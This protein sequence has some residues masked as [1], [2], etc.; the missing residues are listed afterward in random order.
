MVF[1]GLITSE[2]CKRVNFEDLEF[3]IKDLGLG[4]LLYGFGGLITSETC[5]PVNF[6]DLGL[7]NWDWG[8][9]I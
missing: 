5:K 8:L 1:G 3:R 2:T 9:K 6:E 4:C 7:E